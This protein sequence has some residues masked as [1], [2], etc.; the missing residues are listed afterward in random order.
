MSA[1]RTVELTSFAETKSKLVRDTMKAAVK[2]YWDTYERL[3]EYDYPEVQLSVDSGDAM[4]RDLKAHYNYLLTSLGNR[5][6]VKELL[7]LNRP[8]KED[9]A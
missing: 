5:S 3:R 8:V 9:V 1:T 7:I 4:A 6:D 2:A